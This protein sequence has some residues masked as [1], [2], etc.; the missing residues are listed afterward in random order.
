[1]DRH[2]SPAI[3]RFREDFP[4]SQS[5]KRLSPRRDRRE[6]NENEFLKK[7]QNLS[8]TANDESK[9]GETS[10]KAGGRL[11][12]DGSDWPESDSFGESTCSESGIQCSKLADIN[13][14]ATSVTNKSENNIL[15]RDLFAR[16][17][18]STNRILSREGVSEVEYQHISS[19]TSRIL[20]HQEDVLTDK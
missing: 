20:H 11:R 9:A 12:N 17:R 2:P 15:K 16:S 14:D 6:K 3:Y 8:A 5:K 4:S 10:K 19:S 1:M 18:T 13:V 7:L